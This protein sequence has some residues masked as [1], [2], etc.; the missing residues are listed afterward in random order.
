LKVSLPLG[1]VPACDL[2]GKDL[3]IS[4][5]VKVLVSFVSNI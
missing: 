3:L 2:L 5:V 4:N 1:G